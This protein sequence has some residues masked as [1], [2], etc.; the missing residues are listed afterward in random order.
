MHYYDIVDTLFC[1]DIF[2]KNGF[3]FFLGGGGGGGGGQ[4]A[5]I[6]CGTHL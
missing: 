1:R 6:F 4:E 2:M 3:T 5:K